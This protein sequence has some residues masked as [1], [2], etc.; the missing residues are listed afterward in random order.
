[1]T[2]DESGTSAPWRLRFFAFDLLHLNGVD[3]RPAPLKERRAHLCWMLKG[4]KG[5]IHISDEYDGS[6]P[7]FFG[8]VDK[9]GLEGIVSKRKGSRYVS[10][11]TRSWLRIKCWHTDMYD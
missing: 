3:L 9:M 11:E 6:G 7:D 1:M 8:L 5:N 2:Q 4:R 10:G